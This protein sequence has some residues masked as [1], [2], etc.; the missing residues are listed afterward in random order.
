MAVA[1]KVG[2]SAAGQTAL[3]QVA[4]KVGTGAAT[5]AASGTAMSQVLGKVGGSAQGVI[6]SGTAMSG[7]VGKVG[8][9]G[10]QL[11]GNDML[12]ALKNFGKK[13]LKGSPMKAPG[14][15]DRQA[16]QDALGEST[17]VTDL[18]AEALSGSLNAG[19][20]ARA[21][22][23]QLPKG[24]PVASFAKSFGNAFDPVSGGFRPDA[25]WDKDVNKYLGEQR[26]HLSDLIDG[27]PGGRPI[28]TIVSA[29][30]GAFGGKENG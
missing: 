6:P 9:G 19:S 4:S 3:Q 30:M 13:Q 27:D 11:V 10:K 26:K 28:D 29:L 1:Q 5:T 23:D 12:G 18:I 15:K 22:S 14:V 7:A 2:A 8:A 17:G 25:L 21:A 24:S 20:L 16:K